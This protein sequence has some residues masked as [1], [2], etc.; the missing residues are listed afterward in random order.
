MILGA[1]KELGSLTLLV[2]HNHELAESYKGGDRAVFRQVEFNDGR[3]THRF[4]DGVSVISHADL[5]ARSVG[6]SKDDIA[7]ILKEKLQ[8]KSV[9]ANA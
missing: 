8:S 5:V 2:T 3:P 4:V 9:N 6:F 1:F 7:R